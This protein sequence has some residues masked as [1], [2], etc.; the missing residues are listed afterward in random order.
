MTKEETIS[1]WVAQ[2]RQGDK[3]AM[4][5]LA[6]GMRSPLQEHVNRLTLDVDLTQEIVQDSLVKMVEQLHTL[7]RDDQFWPWLSKIAL[8]GMRRH[9]RDN[10]KHKTRSLDEAR[11]EQ[12]SSP[13][14]DVVADAIADELRQ[15][16][17]LA[18]RQLKPDQRTVL[19]L[20]CYEQ[21]SFPQ[22]ADRVGTSE[23]R[24]R[25]LFIRAKKALGKRLAKGGY[26]KSSLL[27]AL[28]IFGKM[29]AT[30]EASL[31]QVK[32]STAT[33]EAGLLPGLVV[34]LGNK[35][36]VLTVATVAA[37]STLGGALLL[38]DDSAD[39]HP[40]MAYAQQRH[41]E[42]D[43]DLQ[44]LYYYPPGSSNGVQLQIRSDRPGEAGLPIW[45]QN[46][47]ANYARQGDTVLICNAHLWHRDGSVMR[48]PTDGVALSAFLDR[49]EGRS[50][51]AG[52]VRRDPRGLL[53]MDQGPQGRQVI[54][55]YDVVDESFFSGRWP[56]R[57]DVI[58]RRDPAHRRGW[59]FFSV[60]GNLGTETISGVGRIPLVQAQV[61]DCAPWMRLHIGRRLVIEETG[62]TARLKTSAGQ[63]LKR[64]RRG[65][66]FHGLMRPWEGLHTIDTV[67]RDA[68][69]DKI[70]FVT[71]YESDDSMATVRL[72]TS[73]AEIVYR[74]HMDRDLIDEIRFLLP[75]GSEGGMD[76]SY[77][78]H[79]HEPGNNGRDSSPASRKSRGGD[80]APAWLISLVAGTLGE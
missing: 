16:V 47:H 49:I 34:A 74:I 35:V 75:D 53:V 27:G 73:A 64:Y 44:H 56:A 48:L 5:K 37:A 42:A 23:F 2:A 8:N 66:F 80:L 26:G 20:R 18:M 10:G 51:G 38:S 22:V 29:T 1:R 52:P 71:E 60:E 70:P 45:L 14:H 31:V 7:Q 28:V 79:L 40:P 6:E 54:P 63:V 62:S 72:S 24:A 17:L 57:L 67:R 78:E 55:N 30:S 43:G 65:T 69:Q 9:Y 68:A 12:T 33:V 39:P 58:D 77:P 13:D 50:G 61:A 41:T 46:D 15:I 25:A 3:V 21:L 32:I 76:F 59:T 36:A 19:V 4:N 11:M